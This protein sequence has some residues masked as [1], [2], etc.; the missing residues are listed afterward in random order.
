MLHTYFILFYFLNFY[1][2]PFPFRILSLQSTLSAEAKAVYSSLVENSTDVSTASAAADNNPLRMLRFVPVVRPRVRGNKHQVRPI[3]NILVF[4]VH[5]FL[6]L[7]A[8]FC[9]VFIHFM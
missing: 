6:F 1:P 2:A 8:L 3:K 9:L 5:E 4:K 7:I